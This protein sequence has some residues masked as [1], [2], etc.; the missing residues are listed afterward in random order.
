MA[1]AASSLSHPLPMD[2]VPAVPRRSHEYSQALTRMHNAYSLGVVPAGLLWSWTI[3]VEHILLTYLHTGLLKLA[4]K[5]Q[6]SLSLQ[7]QHF[8]LSSDMNTTTSTWIATFPWRS[9]QN[10]FHIMISECYIIQGKTGHLTSIYILLWSSYFASYPCLVFLPP[11]L[12]PWASSQFTSALLPKS[13]DVIDI[14]A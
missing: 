1:P 9:P 3:W 10:S 5:G 2:S 11:G 4:A 6:W 7:C 14:G 12:Q 13:L 8:A